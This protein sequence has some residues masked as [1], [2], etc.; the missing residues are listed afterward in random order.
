MA[1]APFYTKTGS[2]YLAEGPLQPELASATATSPQ[3]MPTISE[4]SLLMPQRR[5][6]RRQT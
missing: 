3:D 2:R 5:H 6:H 4:K 1:M